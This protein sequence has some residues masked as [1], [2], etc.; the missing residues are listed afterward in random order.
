IIQTFFSI[1]DV[2][3]ALHPITKNSLGS[4]SGTSS[5]WNALLPKQGDDVAIVDIP[6]VQ[7]PSNQISHNFD[8]NPNFNELKWNT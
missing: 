4:I 5:A 2:S 8:F 7:R 6:P 1:L 3:I